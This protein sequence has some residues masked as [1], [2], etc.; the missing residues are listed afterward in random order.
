[1]RFGEKL[2]WYETRLEIA[3]LTKERMNQISDYLE[4]R[5]VVNYNSREYKIQ[6]I[7]KPTNLG[8]GE[9]WFFKCPNTGKICRKLYS[10]G[11][12]FLHREAF[13]QCFYS[14][15]IKSKFERFLDSTYGDYFQSEQIYQEIHKKHLKKSYAGKLTKKY[16]KLS[17]R[18][19]KAESI[20][21]RDIETMMVFG[22]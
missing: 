14:S 18:L 17:K 2:E 11:G 5:E 10:I 4:V 8:I 13:K 22:K 15:Q 19:I 16:F 6:L 12:Y 3:K 20:N 9:M 1:M 7:P 21:F